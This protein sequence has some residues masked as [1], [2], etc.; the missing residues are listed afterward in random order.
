M[1]GKRMPFVGLVDDSE[2]DEA[3]EMTTADLSEELEQSLAE[4]SQ[5]APKVKQAAQEETAEEEVA[6]EPGARPQE[7]ALEAKLRAVEEEN[8]EY[9]ER[10]VRWEERKRIVDEALA[11]QKAQEEQAAAEEARRAKLAERPDETIDPY[12]AR[13]WDTEQRAIQAEQAVQAIRD[14]QEAQKKVSAEQEAVN[15]TWTYLNNDVK[16]MSQE[17][18]HVDAAME[19]L[20]NSRRTE[21]SNPQLGLDQNTINA[22]INREALMYTGLAIRNNQSPASFF[23][24]VAVQ[25]GYQAPT[26]EAQANGQGAIPPLV[27]QAGAPKTAPKTA[28]TKQA[29]KMQAVQKGQAMQ[30]LGKAAAAPSFDITYE[31]LDQMD[32]D[33]FAAFVNSSPQAA[34]WA[35]GHIESQW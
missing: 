12:G 7:T 31:Q 17:N 19:Y 8:R 6:A 14:Q 20:I 34:K 18:P 1:A 10:F 33:E 13:L 32:E 28:N 11:A 2:V 27:P 5:E 30:G 23:Y 25:R 26:P 4:Q 21:L 3:E 15:N 22:I 9:R 35:N 16:R 24:N 29:Q